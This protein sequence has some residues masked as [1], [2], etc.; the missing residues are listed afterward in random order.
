MIRRGLALLFGLA[1]ALV[2]C[3]LL[4]R[5]IGF[6][7]PSYFQPDPYTGSSLL[8]GA[9]G[10]QRD[11]GEAW[12]QI[13]D[14]GLRDR[15]RPLE[16]PPG[17][18]RIAVLGDSYTMA[19]QVDVDAAWWAV[20]ERE[21]SRCPALDGLEVDAMNFG[22]AGFGTAQQYQLLRKR[23]WPFEPDFV[24]LGF[25]SG[26]D[27][28]DNSFALSRNPMRPYFLLRDGRL[29]LQDRFTQSDAYRART[30]VSWRLATELISR[31]RLLQL[32]NRSR[33]GSA[34]RDARE[35]DAAPDD[36]GLGDFGLSPLVY[37]PPES[38]EW[39]QAWAVTEALL[40]AMTLEARLHDAGFG[41][42]T[43][44]NPP[45]V[46]PNAERRARYAAS[47]GADDLFYPERRIRALGDASGFPVLTLGE[48]LLAH[49]VRT[50]EFLHGFENLRVG[51]GHWNELG[52]RLAG[53][54]S[55]RFLCEELGS[56]R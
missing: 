26:N 23:V 5:G 24:L 16:K 55:A 47:V 18:F 56:G 31:S 3:E 40:R 39:E 32:L 50:G 14:A 25:L 48:P 46:H 30:S 37:R 8:P 20:M 17:T 29:R 45:Q 36:T 53:E 28:T 1:V 51:G 21:L 2:L 10:W 44:T 35:A 9:S 34:T 11:E 15:E 12:V 33:Q 22:V 19:A 6:S 49:A 7:H 43:L 54:N 13:N 42:V 4:L 38:P 52:H 41:V 27:I